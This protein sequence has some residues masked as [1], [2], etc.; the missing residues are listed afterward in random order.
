MQSVLEDVA[1]S[2]DEEQLAE[3]F[4]YKDSGVSIERYFNIDYLFG[5]DAVLSAIDD[6]VSDFG[7]GYI[8]VADGVVANNV[9]RVPEY[10]K[11]V[12]NSLFAI[13]DSSWIPVY[14]DKLYGIH[15]EQYCGSDIFYDI[16]S[17]RKYR[18]FFMGTDVE[19]LNGLKSEL[20]K[21]NPD[22]SGMSFYELPF[23]SVDQFDYDAIADMIANDGAQIIWVALGAPKQCYFMQKLEPYLKSGVMIG[24]GAAFKF[25]SGKSEKRA[26]SWMIRCHLEFL[27]RIFQDPQKQLKRCWMIVRTLPE[28][29]K[30]EKLRAKMT[31]NANR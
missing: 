9:H 17:S 20:T 11:V 4:M 24:V 1:F 28:M 8:V 14:I 12:D 5:R 19:T 23:M 22:V 31:D 7:K 25:F 30:E 16:V 2:V 3:G 15:R 29:I 13:C 21:V 18:M 6:I 27:Y 10:R 26:P